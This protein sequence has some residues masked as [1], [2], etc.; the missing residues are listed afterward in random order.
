M[1]RVL[2]DTGPL[3]GEL[4]VIETGLGADD[5][6][7]TAGLLRAIAGEKVDPQL[8]PAAAPGGP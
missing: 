5:R 8:A 6:V 2:V 4:R 3:V 7:V 1:K